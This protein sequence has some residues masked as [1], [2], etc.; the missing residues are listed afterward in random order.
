M[1]CRKIENIAV[2]YSV[3]TALSG[4]LYCTSFHR[5]E[6]GFHVY[7]ITVSCRLLVNAWVQ[8]KKCVSILNISFVLY[9]TMQ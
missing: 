1:Q 3:V 9:R 8:F 7:T 2:S 5:A 6:R 4:Y